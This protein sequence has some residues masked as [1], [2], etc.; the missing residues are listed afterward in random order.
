M[1]SFIPTKST[2]LGYRQEFKKQNGTQQI[3]MVPVTAEFV[4][5]R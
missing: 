4:P 5:L 2:F 1:N 3:F